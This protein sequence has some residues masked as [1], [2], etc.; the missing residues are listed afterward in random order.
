M[1]CLDCG[2]LYLCSSKC[3]QEGGGPFVSTGGFLIGAIAAD[4]AD[5]ERSPLSDD[6]LPLRAGCFTLGQKKDKT[7]CVAAIG[8]E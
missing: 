2:N 4:V 1:G 6:Y 3:A 5:E 7:R 8:L